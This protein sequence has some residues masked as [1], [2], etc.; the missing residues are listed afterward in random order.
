MQNPHPPVRWKLGLLAALAVMLL[1]LCPQLSLWHARG[2]EWQGSYARIDSDEAAYAAYLQA[3][4]DGRPRRN[5][6][7]TG[8]D[9]APGERQAESLFSI[10]FI[11]PYLMALA[12]RSFGLS[13]SSVFILLMPLISLMTALAIF[14]LMWSLTDDDRVAA[15]SVLV[16]LCLGT[17]GPVYVAWQTLRGMDTTYAFSFLPFLRRFQPAT[18]FPFFFL[19]CAC[20]WRALRSVEARS[21]ILYSAA[22]CLTFG[23]LVFSY[24]YLWTAA[25]AWLV[26][27]AFVLLVAKPAGWQRDIKRTGWIL[28]TGSLALIP[29]YVLLSRRAPSMDATQLLV[30]SRRPDLLHWSEIVGLIVIALLAWGWRRGLFEGARHVA[31][32]AASLALVPLVVFNQQVLTGR[33]LQPLHYDLFIAKYVALVALISTATLIRRGRTGNARRIPGRVLVLIALSAFGWGLFET[34]VATGRYPS[35]NVGMDESRRAALR[36]AELARSHVPDRPLALSTDIMLADTLPTDARL[37]VLWAPH[38][39]VF[40]GATPNE[41]RARIYQ[42]LYYAGINYQPNDENIFERLD[43]QKKYFIN[44]LVGWGRSDPAWNAAWRPVT[45]AE[46]EMEIRNYR[47]FA[48]SFNRERAAQTTLSFFVAPVWQQIDFTNLDRWYERDAGEQIGGYVVY[49]LKLRL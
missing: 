18:A 47:E 24:F 6:P 36:L 17:F 43:P 28:A 19:F 38:L 46:I 41:N 34:V 23:L 39:Q 42:Q 21:S 32:F 12:A 10:Q 27:L 25:L 45:P 13:A 22:S 14:W 26:C 3:L 15:A 16:V 4:I 35:F 33:S 30:L 40:S 5:D 1:S 20:V 8:R 7:Y 48:A 49:R 9:D 29:Y 2:R 31:I 37:A 11:P 44:A